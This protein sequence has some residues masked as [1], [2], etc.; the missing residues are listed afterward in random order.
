MKK[1]ISCGLQE[2]D[3][4][5]MQVWCTSHETHFKKVNLLAP[6]V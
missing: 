2:N 3:I 5:E 6:L 1:K 4:I